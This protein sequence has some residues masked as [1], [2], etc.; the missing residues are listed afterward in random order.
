MG[1]LIPRVRTGGNRDARGVD[2]AAP[3]ALPYSQVR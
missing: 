1:A 2:G 3:G